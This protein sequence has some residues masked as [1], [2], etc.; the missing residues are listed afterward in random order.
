M[1]FTPRTRLVNPRL[2]SYF[3]IFTSGF[4]AVI[5]LSLI[6]EQLGSTDSLV[7]ALMLLGPLALVGGIGLLSPSRAL[8][9][10][11]ASGRRVP[12]FFNGCALAVAAT[13]GAGFLAITGSFFIAGVDAFALSL[14]W[15]GGIVFMAVLFTP[16]MRKFGA[17]TL[18]S[19]LGRRF[20]SRAVRLAAAAVLGVPL[21]LLILAETRFAAYAASWL[22]GQSDRWMVVLVVGLVTSLLALGGMRAQTWTG[23]A[24]CIAAYIAVMVPVTTAAILVSK[25]PIPQM[26]HGNVL[27]PMTRMESARGVPFVVAP[28]LT[29]DLPGA[30]AEPLVKRFVQPFG[31]VGTL[32]FVLLT[33]VV[34]AGVASAPGLLARAGTTPGVYEARKS[35]G[36]AVLIMGLWFMT[37]PAIAIYFRTILL[38]QVVGQPSTGVPPWFTALQEAGIAK[39]EAKT[40]LILLSQISFERDAALFSLP[41]AA[42]YPQTIVYLGLAGA[43]AAAMAALASSMMA[44]A[45]ILSEDV[46][47][48]LV[49]T[50]APDRARIFVARLALAVIGFL[51]VWIAIATPGDPMD[52][53]LWALNILAASAFPVL[54]LSI[55][56]KRTNAWGALAGLGTGFFLAVFLI[57]LSETGAIRLPS[58]IAAAIAAPLATLAAATATLLTPVPGRTMLDIVRD[59]RVPGGETIADREARLL[60][61]KVRSQA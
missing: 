34:A 13:G 36:W 61:L 55:W 43:L 11:F 46:V 57:L 48:S 52:F 24:T 27:V 14:G 23:V 33:F 60:R 3:G 30:T 2:G 53:V 59:L 5:M 12:A 28:Q 26:T 1:A 38:E 40:Q 19:Y 32:A 16:F 25:L 56:W 21:V 51:V 9:D 39:L 42:G 8:A 10:F 6:L 58:A 4:I 47:I 50:E 29:V 49:D 31:S 45:S 41:I 17:Y 18:P 54:F 35:M 20:E 44:A 22:L 7:R 15:I 37:L